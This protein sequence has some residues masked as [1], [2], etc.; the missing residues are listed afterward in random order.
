MD[1]SHDEAEVLAK[2]GTVNIDASAYRFG[3][4]DIAAS[5]NERA[6]ICSMLPRH[7]FAGNTVNLQ[8]PWEFVAHGKSWRQRLTMMPD[9]QVYLCSV[10]N[11]Y[12][13][14]WLLRQKITSH[15]N[16]FYVYQVP[17]PRDAKDETLRRIADRAAR[18]ICTTPDFDDLAKAVGL[19]KPSNVETQ[20]DKG[21]AQAQCYGTTDPAERAKLRAELDGLV[22]HLYGLS[23]TEFAHILGTFPLVDDPI[24]QA[25][26]RAYR[27]VKTG[28]VI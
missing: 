13:V 10:L 24:K 19:H 20:E 8:Q 22:A 21:A 6:M 28:L 23:E 16:I 11:A 18:L 4:R 14:D 25:A 9:Q 17:V 1:I 5:T 27:D 15:L 7:H 2:Q 3:F 12:V 26:L